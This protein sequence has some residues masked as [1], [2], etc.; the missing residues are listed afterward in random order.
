MPFAPPITFTVTCATTDTTAGG[1]PYTTGSIT[2][3]R[4]YNAVRSPN[5]LHRHLRNN[6][7]DSGWE[8]IYYRLYNRQQTWQQ[9]TDSAMDKDKRT[10]SD[11]DR[12]TV[13]L[14]VGCLTS[15]QHASVSQGRICTDNFTCCHTEIEAADQ[16]HPVTVY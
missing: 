10:A 4:L 15:Q 16:T 5:H 9:T 8:A 3:N 12:R 11:K 14:L 1:R 7:H 13:C 6:R 2:D